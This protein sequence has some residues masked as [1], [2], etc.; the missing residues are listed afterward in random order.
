MGI[1]KY[2]EY[3]NIYGNVIGCIKILAMQELLTETADVFTIYRRLLS[4][5]MITD[6]VLN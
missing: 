5:H 4:D 6:A 1:I 2:I 3:S